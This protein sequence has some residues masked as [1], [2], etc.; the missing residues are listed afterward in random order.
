MTSPDQ[1]RGFQA[2]LEPDRNNFFR[3]GD[4]RP[5]ILFSRG[6]SVFSNSPENP[7]QDREEGVPRHPDAIF[8]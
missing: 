6:D 4:A 8:I 5:I 3:G 2:Y 7:F 1:V